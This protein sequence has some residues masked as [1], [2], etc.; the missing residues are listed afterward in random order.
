MTGH[1]RAEGSDPRMTWAWEARSVNGKSLELRCRIPPGFDRLEGPA[2]AAAAQRFRRGNVTL[3]LSLVR[4][5]ATAPVRINRE[6]LKTML[7]LVEELRGHQGVAPATADGLLRVRGIVEAEDELADDPAR[8]E[9]RDKAMLATLDQAID[10]LIAARQSEG[11]HLREVLQ[12]HLTQ[13]E[14]LCQKARTVAAAQPAAIRERMHRQLNDMLGNVPALSDE[15]FAQEVAVLIQKADIREELDRL[16]AHLAQAAGLIA[17]GEAGESIGRK[18]DFLC[19]EFNRE[20]NT[21]CSKSG[22]IE[23]TRLGIELKSAVEQLR[24][25]VQNVE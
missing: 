13:I 12:G 1:G 18:F 23:L 19:Q 7:A 16:T 4:A 11:A 24:E 9:A 2:R 14:T 10:K 5:Q 22:D 25:Q 15:R 21:L 17:A 3:S 20:A 8:I 6:L